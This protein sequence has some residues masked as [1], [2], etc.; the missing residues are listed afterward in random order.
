MGSDHWF[1]VLLQSSS[2]HCQQTDGASFSS[3]QLPPQHLPLTKVF[4]KFS[5]EKQEL[6]APKYTW[7]R[8]EVQEHEKPSCITCIICNVLPQ[9]NK[10]TTTHTHCGL[11]SQLWQVISIISIFLYSPSVPSCSHLSGLHSLAA[12]NYGAGWRYC[13]DPYSNTHSHTYTGTHTDIDCVCFQAGQQCNQ[14]CC[15]NTFAMICMQLDHAEISRGSSL[16]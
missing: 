16:F 7:V 4:D 11:A 13:T 3:R 5:E 15:C 9:R 14:S 1:R 2:H 6:Q 12:G 10:Q 8:A